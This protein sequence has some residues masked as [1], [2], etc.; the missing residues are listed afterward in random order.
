M[1][2]F[3]TLRILPRIGSSAWNS[4]LRAS[5][6]R[7][8]RRVALDDEQ[9][10]PLGV[11]GAAVDELGGQRGR[12]ERVLAALRLL[13][14]TGG[15]PG[16]RGTGDL[17]HQQLGLRLLGALGGREERLELLGDHLAHGG[18]Y[19]GRAEDLLGLALELGLGQPHRDDRG[20]TLED[21]VL[22]DVVVV[23]LE[24][25]AG[26][27]RVVEGLGQGGVE[28]RD[29]G[30]PLRGRDHVDERADLGLV[31]GVPPDGDVDGQLPLDVLRGHVALFVEHRDGLG[32][33]V[34]AGDPEHVGD[35]LT[36]A[37]RPGELRDATVVADLL[38]EELRPAQVA[39]DQL[40][41][42]HD[43]GGLP[44]P[45]D[46]AL[47]LEPGVLGEGLAVRPELDPGARPVL[48]DAFA[49]AGE[50]RLRR[51]GRLRAV[52]VEHAGDAPL[53]REALL[54][55]RPVDVDVH[56]RRQ[57]VD[58]RETDPVE[59]AR[60]VVGPAAE[61]A[62]GVQL[63]RHHLDPGEAGLRLLVGRDAA[64]VVVDLDGVVG[65]EGHLDPA[66]VAPE[67][68]VYAVV[69]DLP[70][71]VHQ[72]ARVGGPDVHA[73][74]FAHR[75]E[76]LE[77]EQVGGVVGLVGDDVLLVETASIWVRI[78]LRHAGLRCRHTGPG[79]A[80]M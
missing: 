62:A 31:A 51:E 2:A 79:S 22:D 4:E 16:L 63:G 17:L 15:D 59:A 46:Q 29:V 19:G 71:A 40:Q 33:G 60:R 41:P 6:R 77:D 24:R 48:A 37:E 67:R 27:H 73:R 52:A 64:A 50:P 70:Q 57:R 8:E 56:P 65:V 25:L 32:E 76:A 38:L 30:A 75:F 9:L 34:G 49:L 42:R 12:L 43:V 3:W 53:E 11:V 58:Y 5:L 80:T 28:P 18:A 45:P 20:Q 47:D 36:V 35:R 61:L 55:R 69:D 14:L 7:A 66:C 44:G 72:T 1:D 68:L 74:P 10:G 21:V 23:D 54:G 78:Y 39:D 26:A 13:V